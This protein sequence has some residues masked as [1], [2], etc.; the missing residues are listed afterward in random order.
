MKFSH[1]IKFG[2]DTV[3]ITFVLIVLSLPA[4]ADY[5]SAVGAFERGD[6][7]TAFAEFKLLANQGD[8]NAQGYLGYMNAEGIGVPKDNKAALKWFRLAAE[9]GHA[10]TQDYLGNMYLQGNGV[11]K[12]RKAAFK[13]FR[14]AAEQGLVSSQLTIGYMYL[15]GDGV[16]KDEPQAAK[17]FR[18]AAEQNLVE[19]Q[20]NLGYMYEK[21]LGV[22]KDYSEAIK[23]YRKS[24]DQGN[25]R[26]ME[27]LQ[28][29]EKEQLR[30]AMVPPIWIREGEG[31]LSEIDRPFS[32]MAKL[33]FTFFMWSVNPS[34]V[35]EST[36]KWQTP[37][38][39]E[40]LA[41]E[42]PRMLMMDS[43]L[44]DS[45][46]LQDA[47]QKNVVVVSEKDKNFYRCVVGSNLVAQAA[48]LAA[49]SKPLDTIPELSEFKLASD[50]YNKVQQ[51][52][53]NA[54]LDFVTSVFNNCVLDASNI[55]SSHT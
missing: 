4:S 35:P 49:Q 46:A 1:V 40:I 3:A 37:R 9:Q 25:A 19:A 18:K 32:T 10:D 47:Q 39:Q 41:S 38:M 27:Q 16:T 29:L 34:F 12:D 44:L 36:V 30:T 54:G 42:N 13:W 52:D 21:G 24:A 8:P 43:F 20:N 22:P 14:L 7:E 15:N 33:Y 50:A 31:P 11:S 6:Y 23:W 5:G 55:E 17:W 2:K 28:A 48:L 51:Q 26:A 53:I 45:N